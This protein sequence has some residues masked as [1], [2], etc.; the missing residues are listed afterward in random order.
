M[1]EQSSQKPAG[2]RQSPSEL[3][4]IADERMEQVSQQAQERARTG[5]LPDHLYP[6]KNL[7]QIKERNRLKGAAKTEA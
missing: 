3:E 4:A 7:E 2:A 1:S 5:D 6:L